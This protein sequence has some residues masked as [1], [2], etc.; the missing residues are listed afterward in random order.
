MYIISCCTYNGYYFLTNLVWDTNRRFLFTLSGFIHTCVA[1]FCT[2]AK[3]NVR[4]NIFKML[5]MILRW[6][7][8]YSMCLCEYVSGDL[9][10]SHWHVTGGQMS[11]ALVSHFG[12]SG[13]L[14]IA[15]SN[16]GW[17]KINDLKI[18]TYRFLVS[19]LALLGLGKDWLAHGQDNV[20]E[21]DVRS[22]CGWPGFP[23]EQH[24]YVIISV[25]CHMSV[26]MLLYPSVKYSDFWLY[27]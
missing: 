25:H 2:F 8:D 9:M 5:R 12:R 17:V 15:H 23:V 13:N 3:R 11:W 22:W 19:R 1:W 6:W 7:I 14:K 27:D 21:W 26:P 18:D 24:Y 20:T 10:R 4:T 16:P